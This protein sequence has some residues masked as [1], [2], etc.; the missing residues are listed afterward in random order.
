MWIIPIIIVIAVIIFFLYEYSIKR[1]DQIV[2]FESVGKILIRKSRFYPKH[3]SL[4]LPGTAYTKLLTMESV[5]KGNLDIK[6]KLSVTVA[7]SFDNISALIRT[8]GWNSEAV[9][10]SA[11][12]L[13]VIINSQVKQYTEKYEIEE[14]SSEKI[15]NYLNEKIKI[16]REKLGLEIIS[17]TIQ[18]FEALDPAISNALKQQESARIMEQTES[19]NQNARIT[20]ARA[21]LK[22]DEEIAV[23]ENVLELKKYELKKTEL[24]KESFLAQ[25]R[26]EEDLTRKKMHL[27]FDKSELE[28]LKNNPELLMLTPQAARLAEASQSLKNARTVVS[29]S[30][31]D[32]SLGS[33][34]IGM[35]QKFLAGAVNGGNKKNEDKGSE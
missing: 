22:A 6:I 20:T 27:E 5:A 8:G 2:L 28:L 24:E 23:M 1:P 21:K 34:L 12:E 18:S 31:N 26:M 35:F 17:L 25:K 7:A 11:K 30:P 15:F 32:M 14:L 3:F 13:E 10:N 9:S 33:D 4:A 16:S 29:L 19:L